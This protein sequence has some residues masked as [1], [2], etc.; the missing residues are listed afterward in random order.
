[1]VGSNKWKNS[2]FSYVLYSSFNRK[3]W[4][5]AQKK[6]L[7]YNSYYFNS[8]NYV[9]KNYSRLEIFAKKVGL[10]SYGHE[11]RFDSFKK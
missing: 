2:M 11:M 7:F 1:M 8:I 3:L 5:P 10:N 6:K 9:H 4:N